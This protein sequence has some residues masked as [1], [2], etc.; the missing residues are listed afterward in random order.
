MGKRLEI[1]EPARGLTFV[2]T[3]CHVPWTEG[4]P[5]KAIPTPEQQLA[6][7]KEAG[8]EFFITCS[9]DLESTLACAEFVRKHANDVYFSC[10]MAAQTVTYTPAERYRSEFTKWKD[11]VDAH[12]DLIVAFG[13]IGLDF[14][15]AKTLDKRE[16]QVGGFREI[17][18]FL[19]DKKKP[20]VLHVR[21]AGPPDQDATHPD[22]P[23]NKP[24]AATKKVVELLDEAKMDLARVLFHCYSGP[25]SANDELVKRGF[26]FSVPSSAY[27][28]E[29][30]YKV[31]KTIPIDRLV[32]ET[33]SPFQHPASMEPINAPRNARYAIAAIA[34]SHCVDQEK[35]A[36]ITVKNARSFFGIH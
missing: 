16:H 14:H 29:R 31:S 26:M 28:F 5:H 17:L 23:Y 27:G 11:W 8:G 20:I 4:R 1:P 32:T 34:H 25:A 36:G 35:V 13:E 15:H 21:N 33:D 18:A 2:D 24:D 30:W 10:G 9:I 19:R 7:F 12:G 3:H 6:A 22:H